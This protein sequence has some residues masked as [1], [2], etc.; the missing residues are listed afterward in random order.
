MGFLS[1]LFHRKSRSGK[2]HFADCLHLPV[3]AFLVKV[4]LE[5]PAG[6]DKHEIKDKISAENAQSEAEG[7]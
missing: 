2:L 4:C 5:R 6:R 1:L 3:G 7:I